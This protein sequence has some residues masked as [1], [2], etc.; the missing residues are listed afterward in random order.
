MFWIHL[1]LKLLLSSGWVMM[2]LS[3]R[4][5]ALEVMILMTL[6]LVLTIVNGFGLR[7]RC[8][9]CWSPVSMLMSLLLSMFTTDVD[10]AFS[11]ASWAR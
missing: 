7:P 1:G 3:S 4:S 11:E 2:T 8:C 10:G 5:G 6:F 9:S